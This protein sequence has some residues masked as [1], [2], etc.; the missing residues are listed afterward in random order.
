[1]SKAYIIAKDF[2]GEKLIARVDTDL[3]S[4]A[5]IEYGHCVCDEAINANRDKN[6]VNAKIGKIS[7]AKKWDSEYVEFFGT[8]INP[9]E[10]Q[11]I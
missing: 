8:E 4:G 3:K 11:V 10:F 5:S 1:M 7:R 2:H 9:G 6:L